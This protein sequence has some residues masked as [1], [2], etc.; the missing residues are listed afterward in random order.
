MEAVGKSTAVPA[1]I[2]KADGRGLSSTAASESG[3]GGSWDL[4]GQLDRSSSAFGWFSDRGLSSPQLSGGSRE[5]AQ[6][7]QAGRPPAQRMS[8]DGTSEVRGPLEGLTEAAAACTL[9]TSTMA[10]G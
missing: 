4:R 8:R 5:S 6:L 9:L 10:T 2:G 7:G 3:A 1:G